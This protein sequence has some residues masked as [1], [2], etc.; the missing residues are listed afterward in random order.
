MRETEK[1]IE[2]QIQ[3]ANKWDRRIPL[4]TDDNYNDLIV[5]AEPSMED[6]VW[7]V[8]MYAPFILLDA[9]F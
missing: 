5:N 9:L 3:E 7:F 4:I 6:E 2:A 1:I 8:I